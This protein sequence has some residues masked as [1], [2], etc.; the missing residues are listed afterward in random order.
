MH[1]TS[2]EPYLSIRHFQHCANTSSFAANGKTSAWTRHMLPP[3]SYWQALVFLVSENRNPKSKGKWKKKSQNSFIQSDCTWLFFFHLKIT[4][5][6]Q[7][8]PGQWGVSFS[9]VWHLMGDTTVKDGQAWAKGCSETFLA[10]GS[11]QHEKQHHEPPLIHIAGWENTCV[12]LSR[13]AWGH[14][15]RCISWTPCSDIIWKIQNQW[16]FYNL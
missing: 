15:S 7:Q 4:S 8:W 2:A 13:L 10:P 5:T 14:K 11:E 16:K 3:A 9:A 1:A 12:T 6:L